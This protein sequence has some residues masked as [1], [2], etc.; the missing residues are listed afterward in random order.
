MSKMN[1]RNFVKA[2]VTGTA[3]AS[4]AAPSIAMAADEKKEKTVRLRMQS[5]WG[6]EADETFDVFTKNV[7]VASKKSLRI[8]RYTSGA[9]VPDA[10]MISA[11]SKGTLDMCEG[12]GGYWPGKIDL[13]ILESG[14]AGAWVSSTEANYIYQSVLTEAA[15]EAYAEHNIHYLA[16]V[17]G[18]AYDLLTKKPIKSLDDLKELKIRATPSVAKILQKF[19]IPTVFMPASELYVGL[20]TGA[21]DGIIF[22]GPIEY[23]GMK[24]FEV[25]KYYTRLNMI[26]PGFADCVLINKDKWESLSDSQKMIL[27]M[28]VDQH[29]ANH[30]AWLMAANYQDKYTKHYEFSSLPEA[31]A[32][33]LRSAATELWEEEA[34]KSARNKKVVD[35][36]KEVSKKR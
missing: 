16:P 31:D 32:A 15:R 23:T 12:Y 35:F 14:I 22:G 20:S 30:H 28:G 8:K 29:A 6:E 10:E 24:I 26:N 18:G 33:K 3:A 36:L 7:K 21:I 27:Q 13:A 11:V 25:A 9:L 34:K 19:D 5:Y 17:L 1:R 4:V 2:A